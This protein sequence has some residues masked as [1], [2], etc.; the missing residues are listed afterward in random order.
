MARTS[1]GPW[2]LGGGELCPFCEQ[3]FSYAVEV[4][5]LDCDRPICPVCVVR[6]RVTREHYCPECQPGGAGRRGDEPEG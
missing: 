2:W 3:R 1:G 5:C 6:V 4:R